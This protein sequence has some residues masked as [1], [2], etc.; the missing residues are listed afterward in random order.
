MPVKRKCRGC[1]GTF[2]VGMGTGRKWGDR[3]C[4]GV[5][6]DRVRAAAQRKRMRGVYAKKRKRSSG[7]GS[8]RKR[9]SRRVTEARVLVCCVCGMDFLPC[10][11][12]SRTC[13]GECSGVWRLERMRRYSEEY[14]RANKGRIQVQANRRAAGMEPGDGSVKVVRLVGGVEWGEGWF[15][16][17]VVGDRSWVVPRYRD[18]EEGTG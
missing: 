18:G 6:R 8:K 17:T 16:G 12:R 5:C 9:V 1:G 4:S 7:V 3:E 11:S 10:G 2:S 14:Y 15:V 13:S